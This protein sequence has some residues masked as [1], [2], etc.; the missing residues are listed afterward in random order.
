[1]VFEEFVERCRIVGL[2][3]SWCPIAL[4]PAVSNRSDHS[5]KDC[6]CPFGQR[7]TTFELLR[8]AASCLSIVH[9]LLIHGM[10]ARRVQID[11]RRAKN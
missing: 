3:H 5:S 6:P 2:L 4:L 8:H 10:S 11:D 7:F 1:M 9:L